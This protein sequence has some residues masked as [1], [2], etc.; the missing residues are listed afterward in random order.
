MPLAMPGKNKLLKNKPTRRRQL[1]LF[2][3]YFKA[4]HVNATKIRLFSFILF[5]QILN[6]L[7]LK[8]VRGGIQCFTLYTLVN[9]Y[10]VSEFYR[11]LLKQGYGLTTKL[12]T[13][14]PPP[15]TP[16]MTSDYR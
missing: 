11:T 6:F 13:A 7:K 9:P 2:Y 8:V 15:V 16:Q 1:L 12:I 14:F 5:N 10:T 4:L 3:G